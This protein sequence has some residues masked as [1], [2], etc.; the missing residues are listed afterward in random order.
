MSDDSYVL[1]LKEVIKKHLNAYADILAS[2]RSNKVSA[3]TVE[4]I[5]VECYGSHSPLKNLANIVVQPPNILII[6]PWDQSILNEVA[7]AIEV[8]PLNISPWKD[9]KFLRLTFPALTTER[10]EQLIKMVNT[11]KEK[12]RIEVKHIRE[13]A[14]KKVN[15]NLKDKLI[16]E[17]Q[18]FYLE[19]E[20]Q[21]AIDDANLK[22]DDMTSKKEVD[23]RNN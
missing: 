12:A 6:E 19:K 22:I 18:K 21:K 23:L 17:D 9:Q 16:S 10:R 8:S 1:E 2:V 3:S 7:H 14:V 4:N 13:D 15:N 11:E 20:I 5:L